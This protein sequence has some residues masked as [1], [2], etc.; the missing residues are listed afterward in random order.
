M[1]ILYLVGGNDVL[2]GGATARDAALVAGLQNAGHS[3]IPISLY[4]PASVENESRNSALFKPLGQT[5]LRLLFPKLS[6]LSSSISSIFRKSRAPASL[7]PL[8][9]TPRRGDLRGPLALS[10]LSGANKTQR[11]EFARLMEFLGPDSRPDVVLL[12]NTM[13]SGLAETIRDHLGCPLVCLSQGSDRFV[14]SLDE[15]F[16][17]DARKLVR[18]HAKQFRFVVTTSRFFAIR[19]AESLALPASRIRVVPPGVD[20]KNLHN[21]AP[22]CR[23]PFT[24]GYL[25]PI[26]KEKGLD[27]LVDAVE[28]LASD[29]GVEPELWIAGHVEDERYWTRIRRRLDGT[30]LKARCRVYGTLEGN[31][32]RDFL[33]GLSV[34]VVSSREPESRG[35]HML[36]AMAAGVPVVGPATGIVPEIFQY[37]NGGLLVSSEAPP[38]M[39]AQALE[40]LA[41][42][43]ETADEMGRTGSEGVEQY[44]SV[45]SSAAWMEEVLEEAAQSP[46]IPASTRRMKPANPEGA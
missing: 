46:A 14:E 22:R 3:L 1:R 16:R 36:E 43:P 27:I 9:A 44:F 31:D 32:R 38:W 21:P 19:A 26:R 39:F 10:L 4:G 45:E 25:A 33:E 17:S 35:T 7:S 18:K 29:T 40:L 34:F 30:A 20:A 42:M 8:S 11:R 24:I 41:S 2:A 5:T 23:M 13:L 12:A 6:R 15:P 37:A 28:S